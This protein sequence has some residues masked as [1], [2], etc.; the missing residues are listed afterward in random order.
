M[1]PTFL[2]HSLI[3]LC[4]ATIVGTWSTT[5]TLEGIDGGELI[6]KV[7]NIKPAINT[8]F[9]GNPMQDSPTTALA[10]DMEQGLKKLDMAPILNSMRSVL[11]NEWDFV[12]PNGRDFF[13]TK[14]V[15]NA[16]EDLLCEL[17]YK[18]QA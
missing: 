13:I 10:E 14:A 6:I 9:E 16:E 2:C 5:I 7:E 1:I 3:R 4:S 15:F 17:K 12:L 8:T 18:F 11:S